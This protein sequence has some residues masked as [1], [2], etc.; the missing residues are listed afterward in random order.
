MKAYWKSRCIAPRILD[1]GNRWRWV[2]SFTPRPL[3]PRERAPNLDM[4]YFILRYIYFYCYAGVLKHFSPQHW[5]HSTRANIGLHSI[6]GA[7]TTWW[8]RDI[9]NYITVMD[10]MTQRMKISSTESTD[11]S[12]GL[13]F[14][15]SSFRL[16]KRITNFRRRWELSRKLPEALLR[17]KWHIAD[18]YSCRQEDVRLPQAALRTL[19]YCAAKRRTIITSLVS[20]LIVPSRKLITPTL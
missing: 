10:V 5:N 12:I 9:I 15:R 11:V 17:Y 3:Y 20:L 1:L 8:P 6:Q 13:H 14:L 19:C 7:I 16:F 2:V 18:S 4:A